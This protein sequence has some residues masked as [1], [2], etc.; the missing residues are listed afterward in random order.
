MI[1]NNEINEENYPNAISAIRDILYM[2]YDLKE[3]YEGFGHNIE[4]GSFNPL[5]YADCYLSEPPGYAFGIDVEILH[6]GAMVSILCRLSDYWDDIEEVPET[7]KFVI[8]VR[9]MLSKGRFDHL[10]LAERAISAAFSDEGKFRELL[11]QI[12]QD[13]VV[14]RFRKLA[15]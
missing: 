14:E 9:H 3:S 2:F 11:V 1:P 8:E 10:P 7:D 13:Y 6:E 12:Y 5:S 15:A 4:T